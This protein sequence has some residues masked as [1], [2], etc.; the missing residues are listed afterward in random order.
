MVGPLNGEAVRD[1]ILRQRKSVTEQTA[2]FL[3]NFTK[4]IQDSSKGTFIINSA[5]RSAAEGMKQIKILVKQIQFV[6]IYA[7]FRWD[8]RLR[9]GFSFGVQYHAKLLLYPF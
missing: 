2:H 4:G 6:V 3:D 8:A 7:V 5:C 9:L 1:T